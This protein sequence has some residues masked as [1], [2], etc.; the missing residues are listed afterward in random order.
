MRTAEL[1][2]ALK[3]QLSILLAPHRYDLARSWEAGEPAEVARPVADAATRE[4]V[5]VWLVCRGW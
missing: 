4:N 2:L 1:A 5:S 3:R